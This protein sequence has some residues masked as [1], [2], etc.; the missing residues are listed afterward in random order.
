M[1]GKGEG[2]G[3]RKQK[4]DDTSRERVLIVEEEGLGGWVGGW[5][6]RG[7]RGGQGEVD[8]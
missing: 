7:E 2:G 4:F 5:V 1:K 3:K 8:T 6:R